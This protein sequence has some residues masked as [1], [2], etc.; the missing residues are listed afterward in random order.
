MQEPTFRSRGAIARESVACTPK[1]P[2]IAVAAQ[3]FTIHQRFVEI[4]TFAA[5]CIASPLASLGR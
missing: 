2:R 3:C 5:F 4:E 1:D